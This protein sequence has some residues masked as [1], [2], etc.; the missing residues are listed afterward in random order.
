MRGEGGDKRRKTI[1]EERNVVKDDASA[2]LDFREGKRMGFLYSC[3]SL[4]CVLLPT[5]RAI[6]YGA[7]NTKDDISRDGVQGGP[8]GAVSLVRNHLIRQR[9]AVPSPSFVPFVRGR[10]HLLCANV[11][12]KAT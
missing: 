4:K 2:S 12:V 7:Y 5:G 9:T 6:R 3:T 10:L 8:P 1:T 11:K